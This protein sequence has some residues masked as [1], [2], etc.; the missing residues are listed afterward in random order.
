[1]VSLLKVIDNPL[2]DIPLVAVLRSGLVGLDEIAL[3]HIRKSSK[4]TSYYEAV[5][6]FVSNFE[7]QEVDYYDSKQQ[8]DLKE[9]LEGFLTLLNT[10][11]DSANNESIAQLIWEIYM[12]T[13]Y[14]EYV[15]GQSNG[16]QRAV[17][18]HAFIRTRSSV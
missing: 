17:N 2:Q 7:L 16:A 13:H 14:L 12:D 18:L 9:R 6:Q 1:M 5:C 8:L 10:W 3:A 15:H 4:N 11:R